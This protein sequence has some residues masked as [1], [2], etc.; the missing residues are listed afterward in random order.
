[1]S[2]IELE[3]SSGEGSDS[4]SDLDLLSAARAGLAQRRDALVS[5]AQAQAVLSAPQRLL[6]GY[7]QAREASELGRIF[8]VA[9]RLHDQADAC[10]VVAS[11]ASS[12]AAKAIMQACTHPFH[13]L[14]S[15]GARGSKPRMFFAGESTENDRVEGILD[16]LGPQSSQQSRLAMRLPDDATPFAG[17]PENR[18]ALVPVG[19]AQDKAP[20]HVSRCLLQRLR[21]NLAS[22]DSLSD[23]C[24]PISIGDGFESQVFARSEMAESE[25]AEHFQIAKREGA[26]ATSAFASQAF[27][28]STILPA[29][30]LGLDC[31]QFNEG[32]RLL[33]DNF[34]SSNDDD[35]L[36][37]RLHSAFA[38]PSLQ[39]KFQT[40]WLHSHTSALDGFFQWSQHLLGSAHSDD[41]RSLALKNLADSSALNL[42][43]SNQCLLQ[44]AVKNCRTDPLPIDGH[45]HRGAPSD[46]HELACSSDYELRSRCEAS[47]VRIAEVRVA[48]LNTHTLGQLFQLFILTSMLQLPAA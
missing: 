1:M 37:F 12:L 24:I 6:E 38:D 21:L 33:T 46:L 4:P 15:R 7:E 17:E 40:C 47:R 22:S 29:A 13:N 44:I 43:D 31:I 2:L 5:S 23:F 9:N 34:L 25:I 45:S 16:L 26:H 27:S 28:A 32:A 18:W 10:V 19:S 20:Q 35:N 14:L 39:K 36:A 8:Q 3:V 48:E 30:I 11:H 41:A 42:A